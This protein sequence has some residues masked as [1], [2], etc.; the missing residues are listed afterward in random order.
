MYVEELRVHKFCYSS[1]TIVLLSLNSSSLAKGSVSTSSLLTSRRRVAISTEITAVA[2][3]PM[4]PGLMYCTRLSSEPSVS[5][6]MPQTLKELMITSVVT[7]CVCGN[8]SRVGLCCSAQALVQ[9]LFKSGNYSRAGT[10]KGNTV[11]LVTYV[12]RASESSPGLLYTMLNC[13]LI[14][15]HSVT[16]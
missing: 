13:F 14:I 9:E 15:Q 2:S 8:Y 7:E 3:A 16:A 5:T 4:L 10:T 1:S 11:F 6:E 12:G